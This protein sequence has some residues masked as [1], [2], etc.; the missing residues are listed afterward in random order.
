MNQNQ[1]ECDSIVGHHRDVQG[2]LK[3]AIFLLQLLLVTPAFA[4]GVD[5]V[6]HFGS[7]GGL[8]LAIG[9]ATYH[10]ST[11]MGPVQRMATS[12]GLA[13]IPGLTVEIVDEFSPRTWF[14]WGDLLADGLGAVS[15]AIAAELINGQLWVSASGRQ[16][17]L[18]GR[19]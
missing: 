12:A 8:G 14:S 19:W 7:A 2:V 15:G 13:I 3:V 18:I 6:S 10:L 5:K 9:T 11:E 16:I 17:R 1:V 4:V